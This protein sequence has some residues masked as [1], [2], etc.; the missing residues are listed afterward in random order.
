[1]K[2]AILGTRG[3]P[4]NY[5]GFEQLAE[6]LALG[7]K[8]KGH[9]VYVYSQHKHAYQQSNWRGVNIIHKFDPEKKIGTA[10]QFIYDLNCILDARRRGFDVILNLGY[11]SSSVWMRLFPSKTR[12]ITNMDGLEWKR[13]KYSKVVRFFLRYAEKWAVRRSDTLV[14]DSVAI[15]HYLKEKYGAESHYIAYGS[16]IFTEPDERVLEQFGV[17]PFTYDLLIA[18]LE[19]ENNIEMILDGLMASSVKG[20]F[21]VVGNTKNKFGSYIEQKFAQEERIVFAGPIYNASI[22][23][24]LRY[25]SRLYFHG[26]S[27]GGTNP[28]LLEAMGCRCLIAAHNNEFNRAVLREDAFYFKTAEEVKELI[29]GD[30]RKQNGTETMLNNNLDKIR[31]NYNWPLIVHLYEELM[32][33]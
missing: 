15:K 1:M 22:I 2:I 8:E 19:P 24:N 32:R 33:R 29:N 5:G 18:R 16:E 31:S 6:Y 4:N 10:G 30:L 20:K 7:L 28:S 11:T 17:K 14:A 25:Y 13:S 12:L 3:I 26:H 21:F 27:V 9:E 23:N